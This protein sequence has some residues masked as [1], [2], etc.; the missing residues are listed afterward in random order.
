M[1]FRSLNVRGP[2]MLIYG[3]NVYIDPTV[4]IQDNVTIMDTPVSKIVIGANSVIGSYCSIVG[5]G[6]PMDVETRSKPI[7][8][9]TSFARDIIIGKGVRVST[10]SIILPGTVLGDFSVV[11]AKSVVNG[12]IIPLHYMTDGLKK[13]NVTIF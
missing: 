12:K 13:K 8:E 11:K 4:F 5:I 9:A 7:S 1:F 10:G 2:L 3:T 6:H